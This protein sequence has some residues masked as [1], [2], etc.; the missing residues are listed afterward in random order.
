MGR[1]VFPWEKGKNCWLWTHFCLPGEGSLCPAGGLRR[2]DRGRRLPTIDARLRRV[3]SHGA[4][5][6]IALKQ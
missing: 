3:S 4:G 5:L 2:A 6:Q 1:I